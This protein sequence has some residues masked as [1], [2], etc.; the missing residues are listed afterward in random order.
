MTCFLRA[1]MVP[2]ITP[3]IATH[4]TIAPTATPTLALEDIPDC[5]ALLET[6]QPAWLSDWTVTVQLL[7]TVSSIP[8][9]LNEVV[10]VLTHSCR[11]ETNFVSQ[12]PLRMI[13]LSSKQTILRDIKANPHEQKI[14]TLY[15]ISSEINWVF[16]LSPCG[17]NTLYCTNHQ[18]KAQLNDHKHFLKSKY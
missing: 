4:P 11:Y 7:S 5:L 6:E 3:K 12:V 9:T 18:P 10:F 16:A 13:L 8:W 14:F 17:N 1:K 15:S 2:K